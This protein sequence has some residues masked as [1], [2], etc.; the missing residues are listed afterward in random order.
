MHNS[1]I[2]FQYDV[3]ID[4]VNF[5]NRHKEISKINEMVDKHKK[6][7]L[8]A[9]RR[10]GKTSLIKNIISHDFC[11]KH[12]GALVFYVNFMDVDSLEDITK[13]ISNAVSSSLEKNYPVKTAFKTMASYIK[14]MSLNINFDGLTGLPSIELKPNYLNKSKELHE[15]TNYIL[16]LS[17]KYPVFLILDE[18]QDIDH[19]P[20]ATALLRTELQ[21]FSNIPVAIL[22][23]KRQLLSKMFASKNSA[24][25][26]F[27]DELMLSNISP[28]DWL[29][30]FNARL[31]KNR[32]S[33][34]EEAI[35]YLCEVLNNVP[36]SISEVGA[37]LSDN[38][39]G[40]EI[41][42]EAVSIQIQD[43][44]NN[45]QESFYTQINFLSINEKS[46]LKEIAM[47]RYVKET[48]SKAFLSMVKP[49][50]SAVT[51]I[52][53]KLSDKGLLEFEI[54]LGY[55]LSDPLLSIF[56]CRY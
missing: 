19:I 24:F 13:R 50:Q 1:D 17:Q 39:S 55:R 15:L 45:K 9:P 3:L 52:I 46:V 47:K 16:N 49:S 33:I 12:K 29:P 32:S 7:V 30:Y 48:N 22:G 28:H 5:C 43:L 37:W 53:K 26:S 40:I 41:T 20:Q 51:K 44:I 11:K 8:Y 14:G 25:F 21:E 6:L 4:R 18:F 38:V 31:K 56:L 23:S 36:N 10:Y 54:D 2:A 34:N 27:G 35:I 42:P